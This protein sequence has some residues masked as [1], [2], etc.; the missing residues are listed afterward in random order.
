MKKEAT[1]DAFS[2][3][4]AINEQ[5]PLIDQIHGFVQKIE[6][7]IIQNEKSP[8][9]LKEVCMNTLKEAS[10]LDKTESIGKDFLFNVQTSKAPLTTSV[11]KVD[12]SQHLEM[13]LERIFIEQFREFIN[14]KLKS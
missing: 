4:L 9:N 1:I 14:T 10:S 5:G 3:G 7:S 13:K 11:N 8:L 2:G 12:H 6:K